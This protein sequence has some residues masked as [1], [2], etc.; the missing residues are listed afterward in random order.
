MRKKGNRCQTQ[1]LKNQNLREDFKNI[2]RHPTQDHPDL[3]RLPRRIRIHPHPLQLQQLWPQL[4][5]P[6]FFSCPPLFQLSSGVLSGLNRFEIVFQAV[7][8]TYNGGSG[9]IG[10]TEKLECIHIYYIN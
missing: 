8:C 4:P 5:L 10:H 6:L 7:A 2:I 3:P 9:S 1:L